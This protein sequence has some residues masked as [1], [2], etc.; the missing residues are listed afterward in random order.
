MSTKEERSLY[1]W[2]LTEDAIRLAATLKASNTEAH[3]IILFTGVATQE[4]VSTVAAQV[5]LALAQ[6]SQGSVLL[7]DANLRSPSVHVIFEV[8]QVPGLSDVI[9]QK[10]P[11]HEAIHPSRHSQLSILPSG[12][13]ENNALALFPTPECSALLQQLRQEFCFVI[14]D[15]SPLLSFVDTTLFIPYTDGIVITAAAGSHRR[16]EILEVKLLLDRL[17]ANVLGVILCKK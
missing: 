11:F 12:A 5:A 10:M 1:P 15:S 6:M 2:I 14:V 7:L 9:E 4:G 8:P 13:G 3:K 17:K 16:A